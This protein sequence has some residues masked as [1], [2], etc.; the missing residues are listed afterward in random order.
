MEKQPLLP[1]QD[2]PSKHYKTGERVWFRT[3][4]NFLDPDYKV[5]RVYFPYDT[6]VLEGTS[7]LCGAAQTQGKWI[8][9][10]LD[11]GCEFVPL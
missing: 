9:G 4:R 2:I 6:V 5:L 3:V 11:P 1:Q 8:L 10:L 7:Y